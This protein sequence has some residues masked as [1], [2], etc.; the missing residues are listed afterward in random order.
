MRNDEI[1]EP[2]EEVIDDENDP[3][4]TEEVDEFNDPETVEIV[5]DDVKLSENEI[6]KLSLS[7]QLSGD[8]EIVDSGAN[9]IQFTR[10]EERQRR[11]DMIIDSLLFDAK[12][13]LKL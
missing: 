8:E 12:M 2:D 13:R 9:I 5:D 6:E 11:E 7:N 3:D 10:E 1:V 4:F